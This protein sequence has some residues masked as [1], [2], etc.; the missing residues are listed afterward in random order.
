MIN[1]KEAIRQIRINSSKLNVMMDLINVLA[2][3]G[4]HRRLVLDAID[5]AA[6]VAGALLKQV[7]E[8]ED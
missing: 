7:H 3:D 6:R 5:N 8:L 1:R 2:E 4:D